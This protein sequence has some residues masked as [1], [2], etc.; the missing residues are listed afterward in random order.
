MR[1]EQMNSTYSLVKGMVV[2]WEGR[3]VGL[4]LSLMVLL[5]RQSLNWR[6]GV[7]WSREFGSIPEAG[8]SAGP[9]GR[10]SQAPE[11]GRR[12]PGGWR[13]GARVPA[14]SPPRPLPPPPEPNSHMA[15]PGGAL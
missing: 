2:G 9:G 3:M 13:T 1:E 8:M 4:P 7:Q 6:R 11:A 12:G 15:L 10:R 5:S 14:P